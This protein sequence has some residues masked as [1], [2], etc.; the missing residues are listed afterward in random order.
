MRSP[1]T[2]AAR[3]VT[4][5]YGAKPVLEDVSLVVPP[6]ARLGVVGPNGSGKTTLLRLLGRLEEPDAGTI[7]R[8][9]ATL[10]VGFL[11]QESDLRHRE[12]VLEYLARR[13]GVAGA[14]RRVDELAD[15]LAQR[16]E[17]AAAH[18]D[19]LD[20]FLALGGDDF[21]TRARTTAAE[22]GIAARKLA[23]PAEALS[24]GQRAR[25]A[26]AAILLSRFDVLLL[27]EP[28]NDLDFDGLALLERF[29]A[30]TPSA[31]VVV[32]HDRELLDRVASRIV[33]LEEGGTGVREWAGGW[34]DYEQARAQALQRRYDEYEHVED[35]RGRLAEQAR[36][37]SEWEQRG[38]GQGRKKKKTKDVKGLY[39]RRLARLER[40]APEKP[41]EPWELRLEL[42][43]AARGGD[44]VARLSRAVV[45]RDGFRL[46]PIDLELRRG[47]RLAVVGPNGSGKTTLLHALLGRL[48]LHAGTRQ[49]GA[50]VEAGELEQGRGRFGR[51]EPLLAAFTAVTALP[52]EEART[53]LAKFGL[54]A[55]EV[56]RPSSSLSPGE[57]TRAALAAFA[58]RGVNLLVLD[59]PTNHLDLPAIEQLEQALERYA[60]ALVL[61]SHD[62][63]F[64]ERVAPT[65]TLDLGGGGT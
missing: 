38:Y 22:V 4:K 21:E 44:V 37:I 36:R 27:D 54:G 35:E 41:F 24:G 63:R 18:A 65:R 5:L 20:R 8:S 13:T 61:V 51:D 46:G 11:P 3:H 31:L 47:D 1:G 48:P 2:L 40:D 45:Q 29:L 33:E 62:R 34:S 58:A 55:D 10:T 32:S 25:V 52:P 6:H 9:P 43:P 19:A 12:A 64:L 53:L 59:E 39:R 23:L 16:P 15:E 42:A 7:E 60:G 50:A 49:L 14:S 30:G 56:L 28:T 57:R 26:L 17:R